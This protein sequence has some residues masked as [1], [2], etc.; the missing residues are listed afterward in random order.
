VQQS[1]NSE[2]TL[3]NGRVT[4]HPMA[5]NVFVLGLRDKL[6]DAPFLQGQDL[7]DGLSGQP[8]MLEPELDLYHA[9]RA[10][11]A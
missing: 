10:P 11:R 5:Y 2:T 6:R 8:I 7:G 3:A 1:A 9:Q 4:I